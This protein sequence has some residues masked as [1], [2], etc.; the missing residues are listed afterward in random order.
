MT[1]QGDL[2]TTNRSCEHGQRRTRCKECNG[3]SICFHGMRRDG[4]KLCK[5]VRP[6]SWAWAWAPP[7]QPQPPVIRQIGQP[8]AASCCNLVSE[9][10]PAVNVAFP[11]D[12]INTASTSPST[13]PLAGAASH[14][15]PAALPT[16]TQISGAAGMVEVERDDNPLHRSCQAPRLSSLV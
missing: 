15:A 14:S 7:Y 1:G 9:A 12:G 13:S 10:L 8:L 4:C 3:G 6:S 2:R 16:S 11:Q 5:R